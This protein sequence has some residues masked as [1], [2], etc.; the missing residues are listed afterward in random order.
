MTQPP[1]VITTRADLDTWHDWLD[2]EGI[3]AAVVDRHDKPRLMGGEDHCELYVTSPY[4]E[5]EQWVLAQTALA[6]YGP[7]TVV[8]PAAVTPERATNV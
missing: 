3:D 1:P 4:E 8:H 6:T 7:F 5:E 2:E